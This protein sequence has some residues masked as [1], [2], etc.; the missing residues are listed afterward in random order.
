MIVVLTCPV[1]LETEGYMQAQVQL[2]SFEHFTMA[3]NGSM[4]IDRVGNFLQN[5]DFYSIFS[6]L[7]HFTVR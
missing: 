6:T 1:Q 3:S 2:L 4:N 7:F 5:P